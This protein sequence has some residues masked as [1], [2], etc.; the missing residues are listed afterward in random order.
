[1]LVPQNRSTWGGLAALASGPSVEGTIST[2][3]DSWLRRSGLDELPQLVL[4]DTGR[5]RLVGPGPVTPSELDEMR[6][7][8][9][10]AIDHVAPGILGV[11]QLHDR[12]AYSLVDRQALDQWMFERWSPK[13]R[14][15]VIAT[16]LGQAFG[17][18]AA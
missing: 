18:A 12:G 8:G 7:A 2:P 5:M 9:V 17:R 14:R 6:E 3:L 13:L 4:V 15:R 16:G 1:M 11:W 10:V